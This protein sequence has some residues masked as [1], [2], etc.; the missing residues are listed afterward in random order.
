MSLD[1]AKRREQEREERRHNTLVLWVLAIL[2]IGA[3]VLIDYI[4][5]SALAVLPHTG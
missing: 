2:I 5:R 1:G 3:A 4:L